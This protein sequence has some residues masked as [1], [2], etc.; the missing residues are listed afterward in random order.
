MAKIGKCNAGAN[1]YDFIYPVEVVVVYGESYLVGKKGF[2]Y[3]N[4]PFRKSNILRVALD[5]R[6]DVVELPAQSLRICRDR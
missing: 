3:S 2:V 6:L 1:V 4:Q 5:G